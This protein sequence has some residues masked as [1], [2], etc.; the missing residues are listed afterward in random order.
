MKLKILLEGGIINVSN[1]VK[2]TFS[3][4]TLLE[5][6]DR[7]ILLEPGDYTTHSFLEQ[8]LK[9]IGISVEMISDIVLTHFH[10]DHA[11]NSIFFPN[12]IVHIHENY[13]KKNYE[14]FGMIIGK[15]YKMILNSWKNVKTFSNGEVLFDSIQVFHTPWHAREHSSFVVQTENYG[16]VFFP[17]DIVMTR[18]EFYDIIRML[19]NDECA[20]FVREIVSNCDYLVF[21]HDSTMSLEKW[22]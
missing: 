7:K 2:A 1:I 19:R 11:Y 6:G 4:I 15:Q 18:V 16:K 14:S 10:L 21:T 12:A 3:T 22:R 17:G 9:E 8:K 20:R 5:H 13:L